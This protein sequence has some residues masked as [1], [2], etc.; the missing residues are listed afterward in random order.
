MYDSDTSTVTT[1]LKGSSTAVFTDD[2]I[3]KI[4]AL[5]TTD[6]ATVRF[7]T[8]APDANGNVTVAAGA[9]VVLINS[10]DTTQTTLTPPASA[11]VLIFQG[12]GGVDVTIN[13]GSTTPAHQPGVTDRVVVGS[14]GNDKIVVTDAKNTQIVLGSGDSTVIGGAG[15]DTIVAGLGNSTVTGGKHDIVQLKGDAS[16]Y[17]V[18]VDNGHAVVTH[19]GT[20]KVTDISKIQYV[21]LDSGKALVFANDTEQAAITTLY[22]TAFGRTADAGGLQYWF[23]RAAAGDSLDKIASDFTKTT[24]FTAA[25]GQLDNDDFIQALYQ[26]TF[27]RTAEDDGL[28]YWTAALETGGATRA[29]LIKS[30]ADIAAANIDG[31]VHTEATVVGS[32]TIVH[33]IV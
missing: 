9:E 7:D 3:S 30:F 14:A 17:V 19:A 28:A 6:N 23:D 5:T 29:Q 20:D 18:T 24:E 13:D 26:K 31:S 11:P 12:K 1:A 4:L 10:S 21:Q 25:N 33:N 32:V 8:A 2:T 27:G 15:S 22:E 16:D